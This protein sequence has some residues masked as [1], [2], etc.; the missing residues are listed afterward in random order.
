MM[1]RRGD[2]SPWAERALSPGEQR[3]VRASSLVG[4]AGGSPR[5]P[6]TANGPHGTFRDANIRRAINRAAGTEV[7]SLALSHGED[8]HG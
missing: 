5:G 3:I 1:H 6:W 7:L 4:L 2:M 8:D